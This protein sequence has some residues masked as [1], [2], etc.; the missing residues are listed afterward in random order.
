MPFLSSILIMWFLEGIQNKYLFLGNE[1]K[2][3]IIFHKI[4]V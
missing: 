2:T 3:Y 1:G 4:L